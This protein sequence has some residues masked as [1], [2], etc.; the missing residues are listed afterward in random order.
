MEALKSFV[1][2]P[3]DV[4]ILDTHGG[5]LAS[6]VR[7]TVKNVTLC[8]DQTHVRIYFDDFYFFAVPLQ[9]NV[10]H[11]ETE[12]SALDPKTELCYVLRKV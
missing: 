12:W 11:S 7:K 9:A 10:M 8:P 2:L 6:F 5:D 4:A 1:E 3:V